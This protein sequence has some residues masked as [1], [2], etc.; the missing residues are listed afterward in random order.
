MYENTVH[1]IFA[2]IPLEGS[3]RPPLQVPIPLNKRYKELVESLNINGQ[4]VIDGVIRTVDRLK[5]LE[6][7]AL[8]DTGSYYSFIDP[9]LINQNFT[10]N[11]ER[12]SFAVMGGDRV[13]QSEIYPLLFEI[14][15]LDIAIPTDFVASHSFPD[16]HI[17]LGTSALS[18]LEFKYNFP[19]K[20]KFY[21]GVL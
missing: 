16:F 7:R 9:A 19:E 15:K 13:E 8:I 12:V 21:L 18:C 5:S 3:F 11:K 1:S 17:I 20:G 4:C 14:S 6:V 2:N 10:P